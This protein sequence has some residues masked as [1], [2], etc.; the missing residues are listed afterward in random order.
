MIL[1]K[2]LFFVPNISTKGRQNLIILTNIQVGGENF[3]RLKYF[4]EENFVR[5]V[6]IQRG[7][8]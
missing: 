1:V 2:I 4:F 3:V 6:F 8:S 5:E 7:I